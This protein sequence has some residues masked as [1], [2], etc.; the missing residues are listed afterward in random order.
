MKNRLLFAAVFAISLIVLTPFGLTDTNTGG[1]VATS[2][3]A[4]NVIVGY[5][6]SNYTE[7]N[8]SA[9]G[10]FEG[11]DTALAGKASTSHAATHIDGSTDVLDGD[12]VEITF[13]PANYTRDSATPPE[14]DTDDDLT[15]HLQ[16]IDNK[17]ADIA[18]DQVLMD[19]LQTTTNVD[20][21][22]RTLVVA[23]DTLVEVEFSCVVLED[24]GSEG[25]STKLVGTYRKDGAAALNEIGVTV[26]YLN[27][28]CG[29]GVNSC[30]VVS[31]LGV[32]T[33]EIDLVVSGSSGATINWDCR[34]A[35]RT[36]AA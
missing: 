28:D 2:V 35:V 10:H 34:T 21:T 30:T 36:R 7:T 13:V 19:S 1:D 29:A 22:I 24:D 4:S 3:D 15:A 20:T 12:K 27:Q 6:P 23:N 9:D 31:Q 8:A 14:A 5:S 18:G 25:G 17:I 11:V 16:G 33:N 32:A 26:L